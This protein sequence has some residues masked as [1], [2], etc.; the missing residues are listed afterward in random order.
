ML[1]APSAT[2]KGQY[3]WDLRKIKGR[4]TNRHPFQ[5]FNRAIRN[6]MVKLTA[7]SMMEQ[8]DLGTWLGVLIQRMGRKQPTSSETIALGF[9]DEGGR[10][11]KLQ[12]S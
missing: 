10:N 11:D 3:E 5:R 8:M 6:N 4:R 1:V 2:D 9:G 12:A 7:I